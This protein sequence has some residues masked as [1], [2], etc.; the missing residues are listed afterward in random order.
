MSFSDKILG[1][2]KKLENIFS[3]QD[4]GLLFLR[5]WVGLVFYASGRTK[6]NASEGYLTPAEHV[7]YLFEDDY[8][9]GGELFGLYIPEV[10]AQLAIYMETL[11][12]ILLLI[13]L[14]TRFAGL[15]L[16][17]MTAV[18]QFYVYPASFVEHSTWAAALLPLVMM[19]G[20]RLSL[21]AIIR[22]KFE[23]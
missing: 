19:G 3:F 6:V 4:Y 16:L 12:P 10:A 15:A 17:G 7:Y 20:G 14:G 18:I 8:G 21:D 22:P 1:T 9:F 13:G 2:F 11:L 23:K 5:T